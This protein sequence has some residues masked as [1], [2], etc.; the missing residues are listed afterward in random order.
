MRTG[1]PVDRLIIHA[2]SKLMKP[3]CDGS[4][5]VSKIAIK[6]INFNLLLLYRTSVD[7]KRATKRTKDISANMFVWKFEVL[8]HILTFIFLTPVSSHSMFA[9]RVLIHLAAYCIPYYAQKTKKK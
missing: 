8:S 3:F 7:S 9:E 2:S 5:S 6:P 1:K 4:N